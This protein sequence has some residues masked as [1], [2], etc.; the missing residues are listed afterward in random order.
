M[1][2]QWRGLVSAVGV[3]GLLVFPACGGGGGGGGGGGEPQVQG[4]TF[5]A[6]N[7]EEAGS[8]AAGTVEFFPAAGE[9]ILVTVGWLRAAGVQAGRAAAQGVQMDLSAELCASG[10]A[11][12]SWDDKDGS[13]DLSAGDVATLTFEACVLAGEEGDGAGADGTLTLAFTDV[14]LGTDPEVAEADVEMDVSSEEEVNGTPQTST[15][16]GSFRVRLSTD[17]AGGTLSM[18]FGG[19]D[20]SDVITR[21]EAGEPAVTLGCFDVEIEAPLDTDG[22]GEDW[23]T[24]ALRGVADVEGRI[25]QFGRYGDGADTPV[26]F[27]GDLPVSGT[28]TLLGY[29]QRSEAGLE[30]CTAVGSSADV[31]G[32][33]SWM[34]MVATGG[35]TIRIERYDAPDAQEPVETLDVAWDDLI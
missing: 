27:E 2:G 3:A 29:D 10:S 32:D 5:T 28:L 35:G 23:F 19:T 1:R 9:V 13:G 7:A 12:L 20:R 24:V 4:Y 30:P 15:Y 31:Q 33:G 6:E 34:R 17:A 16:S 26:R 22:G 8:L 25:L 18:A 21:A 14:Q 11:I